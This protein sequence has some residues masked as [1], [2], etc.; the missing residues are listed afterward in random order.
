[1]KLG[2]CEECDPNETGEIVFKLPQG[3]YDGYVGEKETRQKLYSNVF[4]QDDVWW[5]SG[6]L[7]KIGNF[8]FLF[9]FHLFIKQ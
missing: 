7:L 2:L 6:D 4:E 3:I 5:S 1:M 8:F 9:F